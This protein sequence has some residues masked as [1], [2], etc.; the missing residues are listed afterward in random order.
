MSEEALARATTWATNGELSGVLLALM[1]TSSDVRRHAE[2]GDSS[3][4][5]ERARERA[6]HHLFFDGPGQDLHGEASSFSLSR[7]ITETLDRCVR[8]FPDEVKITVEG[9]EGPERVSGNRAALSG[10]VTLIAALALDHVGTGAGQ[11]YVRLERVDAAETAAMTTDCAQSESSA[12]SLARIAVD[13]RPGG[14]QPNPSLDP[15][16]RVPRARGGSWDLGLTLARR[17]AWNLGGVLC[18]ESEAAVPTVYLPL[19]GNL[20]PGSVARA[21]ACGPP[22]GL[23]ILYV[24]SEEPI[25]AMGLPGLIESDCL[26]EVVPNGETLD[27]LQRPEAA[28]DLIVLG[29]EVAGVHHAAFTE[30]LGARASALGLP[31]AA[32]GGGALIGDRVLKPQVRPRIV[33]SNSGAPEAGSQRPIGL[34]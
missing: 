24:S 22:L 8:A 19:E 6:L 30:E 12:A 34:S 21:S 11:L 13:A 23:H 5:A 33:G 27:R 31:I 17:L 16:L 1:A 9:L 10:L 29:R 20:H 2:S 26:V 7:A 3:R 25:L 15:V 28:F 14:G 18:N 32:Q 4:V